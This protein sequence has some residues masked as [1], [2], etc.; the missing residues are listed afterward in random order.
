MVKN[1]GGG[2]H[3][4]LARKNL[5]GNTFLGESRTRVIEFHGQEFYARVEKKFGGSVC[6]VVTHDN[7]K[8][9]C[10]IRGK[11]SGRYKRSNNL[12]IGTF[13]LVGLRE[14]ETEKKTVDLIHVY[15]P[16][17]VHYLQTLLPG[18]FHNETAYESHSKT[19][20]AAAAAAAATSD[21][22]VIFSIFATMPEDHASSS[23][24]SAAAA[25]GATDAP[26]S[27]VVPDFDIDLI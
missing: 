9:K 19:Q 12:D 16:H 27:I 2:K 26:R 4:N 6:D 8:F 24:S 15:L 20:A 14:F 1:T 5:K 7:K 21:A 18:F 11:F 22:D 3:K 23:S 13:I 25:S 17:D 10:H